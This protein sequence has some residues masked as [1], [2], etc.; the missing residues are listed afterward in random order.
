MSVVLT[1]M[2]ASSSVSL[3]G[4]FTYFPA[5]QELHTAKFAPEYFPGGHCHKFAPILVRLVDQAKHWAKI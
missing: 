5:E 2:Q 4:F 1:V 3:D